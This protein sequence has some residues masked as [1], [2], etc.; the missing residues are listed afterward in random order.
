MLFLKSEESKESLKG[1]RR[2]MVVG[3]KWKD[4]LQFKSSRRCTMMF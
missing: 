2:R 3:K 1:S 4:V